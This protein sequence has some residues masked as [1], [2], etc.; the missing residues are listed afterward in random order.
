[1]PEFLFKTKPVSGGD[2]IVMIRVGAFNIMH[3]RKKPADSKGFWACDSGAV[4]VEWVVLSAAVL[5]LGAFSVGQIGQGSMDLANTTQG[6]LR[7]SL[8]H[9]PAPDGPSYAIQRLSADQLAQWT[10]TYANQTEA[11]LLA[12][13]HLRHD[14]FTAHLG[15]QQWSQAL[16]RIDYYHIIEQE[17]VS[18]TMTRPGDLPSA[19]LL[20]D[21]YNDARS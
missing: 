3:I 6:S 13:V 12:S 5:G 1:M 14:Q 4:S 8:S 7:F 2:T 11:Q 9:D 16:Q 15:A 17:L 19:Q 18:R 10:T 20:F 21:M